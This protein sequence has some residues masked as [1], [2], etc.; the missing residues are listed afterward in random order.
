MSEEHRSNALEE[1]GVHQKDSEAR[2]WRVM[3]DPLLD[4]TASE[5]APERRSCP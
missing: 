1:A 2:S 5:A 3:H 4:L